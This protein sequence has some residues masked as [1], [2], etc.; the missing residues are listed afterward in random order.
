MLSLHIL[1]KI[2]ET[3]I[4]RVEHL[5]F[6]YSIVP[7]FLLGYS[8]CCMM[9]LLFIDVTKYIVVIECFCLSFM[10]N[11]TTLTIKIFW[12]GEGQLCALLLLLPF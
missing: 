12:F 3:I 4:G 6:S 5:F 8:L 11:V 7:L 10:S 9:L 2:R 1:S